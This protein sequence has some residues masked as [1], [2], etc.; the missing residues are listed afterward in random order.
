[1]WQCFGMVF[2]DFL[3]SFQKSQIFGFYQN[4]NRKGNRPAYACS[5]SNQR[6]LSTSFLGQDKVHSLSQEMTGQR[7]TILNRQIEGCNVGVFYCFCQ[8]KHCADLPSGEQ[9]QVECIPVFADVE[10]RSDRIHCTFP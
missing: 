8:L 7:N 1:M 2:L 6:S 10:P 5:T 9:I 4:R 3:Y